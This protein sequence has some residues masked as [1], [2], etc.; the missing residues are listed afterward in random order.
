[1]SFPEDVL[2]LS[3][4]IA[5]K[6]VG[7]IF[8]TVETG[9]RIE[10]LQEAGYSWIKFFTGE[11]DRYGLPA[12]G[13]PG[14][15]RSF[16]QGDSGVIQMVAPAPPVIG[17]GPVLNVAALKL[18]AHENPA[19]AFAEITGGPLFPTK[20]IQ[21]GVGGGSMLTKLDFG[22][23]T[24]NDGPVAVDLASELVFDHTLGVNPR[25]VLLQ[26]LG[27]APRHFTNISTNINTITVRVRDAAGAVLAPGSAASCAFL[28][29]V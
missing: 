21:P 16:P 12:D 9:R 17:G 19:F 14:Y 18:T 6:V 26:N 5:D 29:L 3:E 4:L 8:K 7:A 22:K 10:I 25:T 15:L 2:R 13:V 1:M 24:D 28:V 27:G 20:G 11:E 23:S